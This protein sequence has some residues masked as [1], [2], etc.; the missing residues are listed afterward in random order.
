[1]GAR[2]IGELDAQVAALAPPAAGPTCIWQP[3]ASAFVAGLER[4]DVRAHPAWRTRLVADARFGAHLR[5]K[6]HEFEGF[7]LARAP[8]PAELSDS[9][10]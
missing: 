3:A 2:R 10:G 7:R 5:Q 8:Q 6:R 1:M 4:L 9:P